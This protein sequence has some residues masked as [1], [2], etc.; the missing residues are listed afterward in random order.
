MCEGLRK[1]VKDNMLTSGRIDV[2][3]LSDASHVLGEISSLHCKHLTTSVI[4]HEVLSLEVGH[5]NVESLQISDRK[6]RKENWK[7]GVNK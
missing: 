5:R 6:R 2:V 3:E 4:P 7:V 1:R